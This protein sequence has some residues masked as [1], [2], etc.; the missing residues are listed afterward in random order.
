MNPLKRLFKYRCAYYWRKFCHFCG[1][2]P[3][4]GSQVNFTRHGQA[5][6]PACQKR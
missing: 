4:C 3:S 2:C 6:C 1:F 5:I